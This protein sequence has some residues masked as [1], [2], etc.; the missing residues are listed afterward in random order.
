MSPTI[1]EAR[2]DVETALVALFGTVTFPDPGDGRPAPEVDW[3]W[4]QDLPEE[5]VILGDVAPGETELGAHSAGQAAHHDHQWT[6][7]VLVFAGKAGQTPQEA[8]QRISEL[9]GAVERAVNADTTV[10]AAVAVAGVPGFWMHATGGPTINFDEAEY[11]SK[12][13][14]SMR[15][16]CNA[17]LQE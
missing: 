7:E 4:H 11:G 5:Y 16:A 14:T 10:A 8:R 1:Y 6:V 17:Y 15:I 3:G 9:A 12:S 2:Y 13:S